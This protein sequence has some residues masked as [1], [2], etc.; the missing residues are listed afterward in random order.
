MK[1]K[2]DLKTWWWYH[3]FH[4]LIAVLVL[5]V[6]LYSV[7]PDMGAPKADY[8]LALIS[9]KA[10]PSEQIEALRERIEALA[11]DRSGDGHVLVETQFYGADLSG[12]T[13]GTVNYAEASRLD[14]DLVGKVSELLFFD[15]LAGFRANVAVRTSEPLPCASLPA[16]A[17]LLPEGWYAA[18]R[19]DCGAEPLWEALRAA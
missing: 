12:I 4:V 19:T 2:A 1:K 10:L 3:R 13:A 6:V 5:A 11:D 18:V 14:A 9:V 8:S 17:G 7:L 15:D 16:L